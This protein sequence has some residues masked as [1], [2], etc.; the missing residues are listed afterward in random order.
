MRLLLRSRVAL[1]VAGRPRRVGGVTAAVAW[2]VLVVVV[3][4]HEAGI[5]LYRFHLRVLCPLGLPPVVPLPLLVGSDY[6]D[7]LAEGFQELVDLNARG[8]G[9]RPCV[10]GNELLQAGQI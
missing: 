8:V 10:P 5:D 1:A 4:R 7:S 9:G 3:G 2:P 6:R